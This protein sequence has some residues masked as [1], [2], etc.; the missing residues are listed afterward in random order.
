VGAPSL[1]GGSVDLALRACGRIVHGRRRVGTKLG[2]K[3]L[4]VAADTGRMSSRGVTAPTSGPAWWRDVDTGARNK[5]RRR[6]Q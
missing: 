3:E 6:N 5:S 1:A 2:R 4:S